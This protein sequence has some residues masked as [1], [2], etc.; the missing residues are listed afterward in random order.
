MNFNPQSALSGLMQGSPLGVFSQFQSQRSAGPFAGM[1]GTTD[2]P[3]PMAMQQQQD[4]LAMLMG[5]DYV[6]SLMQEV[7]N[8]MAGA[9][10]GMGLENLGMDLAGLGIGGAPD[11][12]GSGGGEDLIGQLLPMLMSLLEGEG[13]DLKQVLGSLTQEMTGSDDVDVADEETVSDDVEEYDTATDAPEDEEVEGDDYEVTQ[14]VADGV[15]EDYDDAEYE[16]MESEEDD[17]VVSQ[18]QGGAADEVDEESGDYDASA[19]G[20]E[21][22][23]MKSKRKHCH[24]QD[25]DDRAHDRHR[26]HH[27]H[28]DDFDIGDG[29]GVVKAIEQLI[30]LLKDYLTELTSSSE[31]DKGI[32]VRQEQTE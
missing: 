25:R 12:G 17:V 7:G 1:M 28:E 18:T 26:H 14:T 29:K 24:E 10:I 9:S 20:N 30:P 8:P 32:K 13:G 16:E 3:F 4:P 2:N 21:Y 5:Q 23:S 15:D 27:K 22:G 19:A 6:S 31:E 11:V